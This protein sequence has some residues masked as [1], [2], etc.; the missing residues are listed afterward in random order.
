MERWPYRIVIVLGLLA[1]IAPTRLVRFILVLAVVCLLAD[2]AIAAVHV[3][4]E[5]KMVAKPTAGMCRAAF[6]RR[7]DRRPAGL[8][9][10]TSGQA[11]R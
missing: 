11:V 5:F 3:G 2:A 8:D 9:A 10:G 7:V 4:V 6:H 1:A